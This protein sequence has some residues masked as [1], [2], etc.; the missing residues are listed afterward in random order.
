MADYDVIVLGGG[1]GGSTVA[2]RLGQAGRRVLVAEPGRLGGTSVN[3]GPVPAQSLLHA[4][5]TIRDL[6][7]APAEGITV[8]GLNLDW[9][10]LQAKKDAA[11]QTLVGGLAALLKRLKVEV[12]PAAGRFLAPGVVEVGGRRLTADHVVIATGSVPNL[13]PL[14][15]VAHNPCVVDA[16]ALLASARVPDRLTILGGD[17]I[18]LECASLFSALGSSVT[19][20]E[21]LGEIAPFMDADIAQK[22]RPAMRP[23]RFRLGCRLERLDGGTV[24]YTTAAGGA[25]AIT[26]DVVL[27]SLGRRPRFEGWGAETSGLHI[28]PRGV[29][30]DD[31]LRTSLPGVW[32]VGD[33]TG[34]GLGANT[35]IRSGEIAAALILDPDQA[36]KGQVMRWE[37]VPYTMFGFP[38]AAGVGLTERDAEAQ[39]LEVVTATAPLVLSERCVA[40]SGLAATG[41]VKVVAERATGQL[42]GLHLFGPHATEIIWG[43]AGLLELELTVADVRQIVFPHPTVAE[44]IREACWAIREQ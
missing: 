38:E 11:V 41:A 35:A 26:S 20:L 22:L 10:A 1:P 40:E 2:Q 5:Q 24:Y 28:T 18:G 9:A 27:L 34:R 39:G 21:T 7:A 4:A 37:A 14:R 16:A 44:G 36:A 42:R 29:T 17:A 12:V 15:G 25:E 13:P 30:V 32:A 19:L 23:V 8:T 43:A 31:R 3:L 6:R 33:V